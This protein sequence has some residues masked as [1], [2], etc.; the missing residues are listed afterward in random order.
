[1][2]RRTLFVSHTHTHGYFRV[3]S[4]HLSHEMAL[5]GQCV[6]HVSTSVSLVQKIT[7]RVTPEQLEAVRSSGTRVR[8]G[9]TDVVPRVAFPLRF[10]P[11]LR[12]APVFE[13][14]GWDEA[15]VTYVDEPM[16]W[17]RGLRRLSKRLV[18]RPT[19]LYLGGVKRRRQSDIL[20][21]A[22][23][24]VATSGAVLDSLGPISIPSMVLPNGV[25]Y[26]RFATV[27][28]D[29]TREK[30][31]VYIGALDGRFDWGTVISL[32]ASFSDW[33]F[34]ICGP[35]EYPRD[36]PTNVVARGP[37]AYSGLPEILSE[38]RVGLLP[39]SVD[40]LNGGRSPM[41]LYEYLSAG[42]FVVSLQTPQIP[43][44]E[45]VGTFS[46]VDVRGALEAFDAAIS[47]SASGWNRAG[48]AIA[49]EED[50]SK[51]AAT[52][53]SFASAL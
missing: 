22:D 5:R 48:Q 20:R 6:A 11:Q 51:K 3:G 41:K 34:L 42:L 49:G 25:E 23:G 50:W 30:R 27:G 31:A 13:S 15:D 7:G 2:S 43:G 37:I 26:S 40:P 28:A 17:S 38:S 24:V 36:L 21:F 35:G 18:Y 16:M 47:A 19:D 8:D 4:H 14:L 32:A 39:L 9:V 45:S 10:V 52:L 1:M 29:A 12:W 44:D 46:Y 33:E 53:E